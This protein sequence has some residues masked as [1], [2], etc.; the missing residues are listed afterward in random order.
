MGSAHQ[1]GHEVIGVDVPGG[2][3]AA[4]PA[5]AVAGFRD[6]L[7]VLVAVRPVAGVDHAASIMTM[8]GAQATAELIAEALS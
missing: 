1:A 5:E 7:D 8:A 4:Y 6:T 3:L 2:R